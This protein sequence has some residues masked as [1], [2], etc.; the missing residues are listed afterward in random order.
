MMLAASTVSIAREFGDEPGK[1]G[2]TGIRGTGWFLSS[3]SIVTAAHVAE[4]MRLTNETW[5]T[6]TVRERDAQRSIPV[7]IQRVIGTHAERLALLEL[8][9]PFPKA[10]ALAIRAE[11]LVPEEA[12]ITLAYPGGRLRQANGRFVEMGAEGPSAGLAML[13]LYDGTDRLALDH[14]ASGAPVLDCEGRVV[15]IVANVFAQTLRFQAQ[16]IRI[17]T[18]WQSPNVAA[19]PAAALLGFA[20]P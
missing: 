13:E 3:R 18:P 8:R 9:D 14:G 4:A 20:A 12:L 2:V 6:V 5:T 19:V 15:A 16:V 17:S 7:R 10:T 1:P 11:P